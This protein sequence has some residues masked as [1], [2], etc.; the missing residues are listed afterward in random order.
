MSTADD[1]FKQMSWM[2]G[3]WFRAVFYLRKVNATKLNLLFGAESPAAVTIRNFTVHAFPDV[4]YRRFEKGIIMVNPS[5]H[6]Y[7]FDLKSISPG[8]KYYRLQAT[9]GQDP[10][11]NNGKPAADKIMLGEREG[12]FLEIK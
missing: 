4:A 1:A 11:T 5:Y 12:L 8:K 9:E 6:N 2:N 10:I 3:R 7:E